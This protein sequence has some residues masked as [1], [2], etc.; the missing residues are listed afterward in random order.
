MS[1]GAPEGFYTD[2][3]GITRKPDKL[4][5][6][7]GETFDPTGMVVTAYQ[8]NLE[9]G[10]TVEEEIEDYQIAPHDPHGRRHLHCDGILCF[11]RERRRG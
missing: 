2:R 4:T 3:I 7:T 5:Y 8:V 6:N 10:E 11:H 1:H 9:T